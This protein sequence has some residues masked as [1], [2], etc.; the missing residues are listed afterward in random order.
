MAGNAFID[1][2]VAK[3]KAFSGQKRHALRVSLL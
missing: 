3:S 1:L 2:S